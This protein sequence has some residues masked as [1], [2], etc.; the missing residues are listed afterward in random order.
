MDVWC[1]TAMDPFS[2]I[3]GAAGL[4]GV[5]AKTIEL[6]AIYLRRARRD[7]EAAN[8][9]LTMLRTLETLLSHLK[10]LLKNDNQHAFSNTSVLVTSTAACR[11]RLL[12]VHTK[13]EVAATQPRRLLRWPL[14]GGHHRDM[15]QDLRAFAQWIQFALAIDGAALMSK[16]SD[17]LV[18]V[19]RS[20][21]HTYN[22]LA[23]LD[24]DVQK[25]QDV[26]LDRSSQILDSTAALE[27][28]RV[29]N[30]ISRDEPEQKHHEIRQPRLEGTGAWFL[31]ESSFKLWRDLPL[32]DAHAS[33]TLWCHG[34]TG[35]GK[36]ILAYGRLSRPQGCD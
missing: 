14:S 21:L 9:L 12:T 27:R 17:E 10:E 13:L 18:Q 34:R 36:S 7:A 8:E 2:L 33:S 35:S 6:T 3:V 25:L 32:D 4:L 31:Q 1:E 22:C 15:M 20:Q 19:L 16:T 11:A 5:V 29:L 30:W 23:R 24:V 26:V 28:Q